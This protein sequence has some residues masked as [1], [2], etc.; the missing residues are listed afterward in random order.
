MRALFFLGATRLSPTA[1]AG[2]GLALVCATVLAGCASLAPVPPAQPSQSTHSH[3]G[4]AWQRIRFFHHWPEGEDP[5]W[6]V[7]ALVAHR[8]V[9]PALA[10]HRDEIALWRFHRR[11]NG[12]AAGHSLSFLAYAPASTNDAL[13]T[14]LRSDPLVRQ[15]IQERVL[16][17]LVCSADGG[18]ID[19]TSDPSW[20]LELQRTWPYFIM[21]VSETW[22]RLIDEYARAAE[23]GDP[24]NLHGALQRYREIEDRVSATWT[25]EGAHAFLHHL[26]G[27]FGYE[28]VYVYP[29]KLQRF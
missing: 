12:D 21:G 22:L 19:A 24:A 17:K 1:W 2:P 7:D 5:A 26:N 18:E 25:D 3:P 27:I 23:P 10:R 13:C 15:L 16:D 28:P 14:E 9:G 20:P 29:R 6:H 8:V 11:A 4:Q